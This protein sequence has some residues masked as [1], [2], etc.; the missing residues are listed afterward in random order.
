MGQDLRDLFKEERSKKHSL[1]RGHE[2]R[3]A[4]RLE[5]AFPPQQRNSTFFFMKIAASIVVLI[6][7]S[8]F[9]YQKY[10][11]DEILPAT[12]VQKDPNKEETQGI[13]LGDLSPD[14][15]RVEDYYVATINM[16]L[17]NLVLSPD[18]KIIV[19]DFMDRLSELNEEYKLLNT[20]LNTIGPNDQTINALIQ[21]LQL[22]LQLLLK[23]KEKL[24]QLK[25]S[26]N[27]TVTTTSV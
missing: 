9:V 11:G 12:V 15:K 25:S 3:F 20:E 19:D 10:S 4:G 5:E 27:E 16:E 2:E 22:R 13:S 7:I 24:N 23:L 26:K 1:K 18:N 6:S 14:L 8:F 21:N 17:S